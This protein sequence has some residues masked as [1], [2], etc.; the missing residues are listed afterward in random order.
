[1]RNV[2]DRNV[3][4]FENN[5]IDLQTSI[6]SSGSSGDDF[7]NTNGWIVSNVRVV[8]AARDAESQARTSTFQNNFFVI[9]S[10]VA[11]G[12][13]TEIVMTKK[14]VWGL[15]PANLVL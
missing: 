13:E 2:N 7:R 15:Q 10:F 4:N 8:C 12:L 11:V 1:M 9:P 3:I 14:L 6:H 5:I